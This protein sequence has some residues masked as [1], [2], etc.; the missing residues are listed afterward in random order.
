M[1]LT[2]PV[3]RPTPTGLA[4]CDAMMRGMTRTHVE[5]IL[6]A[7]PSSAATDF[8]AARIA[9]A[10]T[11]AGRPTGRRYRG[12]NYGGR[13]LVVDAG[14]LRPVANVATEGHAARLLATLNAAA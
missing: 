12:L 1:D 10:Y 13:F 14:T 7:A 2:A 3:T 5:H 4:A 11:T 8:Y 6:A 9:T